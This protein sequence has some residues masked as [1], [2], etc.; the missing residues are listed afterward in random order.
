MN[1]GWM[2][3]NKENILRVSELLNDKYVEHPK[4]F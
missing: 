1:I 4:R 2:I 3:G